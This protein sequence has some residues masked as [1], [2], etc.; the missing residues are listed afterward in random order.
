M[1]LSNYIKVIRGLL[2][3]LLYAIFTTYSWAQ[4]K[5][6][7][8]FL[9]SVK[10]FNPDTVTIILNELMLTADRVDYVEIIDLNQ[11]GFGINDFLKIHPG[12]VG[13]FL[14]ELDVSD[15]LREILYGLPA[16]LTNRI[17]AQN[18]GDAREYDT[19]FKTPQSSIFVTLLDILSR[20]YKGEEIKL[21]LHRTPEGFKFEMSNFDPTLAQYHEPLDSEGLGRIIEK[22]GS[23]QVMRAF[24]E[25]LKEQ[26]SH[27]L[28][29][30]REVRID[31]VY[32][33]ADKH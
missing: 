18:I 33:S 30:V 19:R 3:C 25:N 7:K 17:V 10:L 27:E 21:M 12:G 24:F 13:M 16:P 20:I 8:V 23:D 22:M 14:S 15:K 26:F 11:D 31:T 28:L 4:V 6:D 29:I 1:G 2:L 32:V 5:Q 9:S